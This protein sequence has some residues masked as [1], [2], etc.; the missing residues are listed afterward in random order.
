MSNRP[1]VPPRRKAEK[2]PTNST[3]EWLKTPTG[4]FS[5]VSAVV[6]LLILI[7]M[8][9]G[10]SQSNSSLDSWM[11]NFGI[12]K[13]KLEVACNYAARNSE[14]GCKFI[15]KTNVNRGEV[16]MRVPQ[17]GLL[18][19]RGIMQDEEVGPV[20][21]HNNGT[22]VIEAFQQNNAGGGQLPF[23]Y[24]FYLA[25]ERRK[26]S[27]SRLSGWFEALPEAYAN[28]LY[29]SE[30]IDVC[31]DSVMRSEADYYRR[32]LNASVQ[33]STNICEVRNDIPKADLVCRNGAF[34]EDELRWALSTYL[35]RNFQDQA[36][37]LGLD[38]ANHRNDAGMYPSWNKGEELLD[39][40]VGQPTKKG[41]ELFLN[42]GKSPSFLLSTY[43][44]WDS[45]ASTI[46]SGI[47]FDSERIPLLKKF[48]CD[49]ATE[50]VYTNAGRPR[51]SLVKCIAI[52]VATEEQRESKAAFNA[53]LKDDTVMMYTYGNLTGS[54]QQ[55]MQSLPRDAQQHEICRQQ[56]GVPAAI[57]EYHRF[58]TDIIV[59]SATYVNERY[60]KYA[61]RVKMNAP[62]ETSDEAA[63]AAA[64]AEEKADP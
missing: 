7:A 19:Q 36:L 32:I 23:I 2:A 54:L 33:A 63:E 42:Y 50:M 52:L 64:T 8:L 6:V 13:R 40:I 28:S 45:S 26:G 60:T 43:G 15:A 22:I 11:S 56:T 49:K 4:M 44:F 47:N 35:T 1:V 55:M 57:A 10:G 58:M 9:P 62:P 25:N 14:T 20:L 37:V 59:R 39:I 18:D 24:A 29:W 46:H 5:A 51:E 12:R 48:G 16:V 53:A 61:N 3:V 31:M 17:A 27:Y 34:S 41:E 21:S 30:S 38:F